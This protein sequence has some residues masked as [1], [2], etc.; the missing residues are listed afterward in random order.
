MSYCRLP[1]LAVVDSSEGPFCQRLDVR[2]PEVLSVKFPCS[3]ARSLACGA[4]QMRPTGSENDS[5]A[6]SQRMGARAEPTTNDSGAFVKSA[7]LLTPRRTSV[8]SAQRTDGRTDGQSTPTS[9]WQQI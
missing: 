5:E 4:T 1:L 7:S 8:D 3:T 2:V 6:V 9:T